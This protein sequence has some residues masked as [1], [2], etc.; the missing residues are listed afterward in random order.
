MVDKTVY[1]NSS[2]SLSICPPSWPSRCLRDSAKTPAQAATPSSHLT[3]CPSSGCEYH[4]VGKIHLFSF[5]VIR[6]EG[7]SNPGQWQCLG[8]CQAALLLAGIVGQIQEEG[9]GDTSHLG[10]GCLGG[11]L[12][13][14]TPEE[15]GQCAEEGES[16]RELLVAFAN[17]ANQGQPPYL[18]FCNS[19]V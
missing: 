10:N 8:H 13:A 2:Y 12:A 7:V 11:F 1:Y 4:L 16:N 18:T 5:F 9:P 19:L 17:S 3:T 14:N 6:G 15:S